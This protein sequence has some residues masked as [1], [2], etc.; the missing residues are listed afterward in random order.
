MNAKRDIVIVTNTIDPKRKEKLKQA[1]VDPEAN[2]HFLSIYELVTKVRTMNLWGL[3]FDGIRWENLTDDG[4]RFSIAAS[5]HTLRIRGLK[6]I[7]DLV[8]HTSLPKE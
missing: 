6:S 2:Y 4:R 5:E 1:H 3:V 8:T 7:H